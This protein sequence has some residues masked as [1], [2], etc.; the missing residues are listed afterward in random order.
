MLKKSRWVIVVFIALILIAGVQRFLSSGIFEMLT[1]PVKKIS[2]PLTHRISNGLNHLEDKYQNY[3]NATENV[4]QIPKLIHEIETLKIEQKRLMELNEVQSG[5]VTLRKNPNLKNIEL[6]P[7]QAMAHDIYGATQVLVIDAGWRDGIT[8]GRVMV[9]PQGLV[10]RV[11]E[12]FEHESRVLLLTD[13]N[14]FVEVINERTGLRS[15]V[16]G[17]FQTLAEVKLPFIAQVT[18]FEKQQDFIEGDILVT[19]GKGSL[20]PKGIPVGRIVSVQ[21]D[22]EKEDRTLKMAPFYDPL[23]DETL[24]IILNTKTIDEKE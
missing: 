2:L 7:V 13:P 4:K 5:V 15:V 11:I 8:K 16:S 10:G 22:P 3:V 18:Y 24:Y 20:Y 12:I 1:L 6:M 19:S 21:I 14:F 9:S 23:V 17:N